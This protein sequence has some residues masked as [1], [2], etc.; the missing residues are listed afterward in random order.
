MAK[1][2]DS[3]YEK[4]KDGHGEK[5]NIGA[6]FSNVIS[7]DANSPVSLQDFYDNYQAFLANG[8]FIYTGTTKP[9]NTAHIAFWVKPRS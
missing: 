8:K 7:N 6:K 5:V 4:T 1:I 2:A 9:T 3:L